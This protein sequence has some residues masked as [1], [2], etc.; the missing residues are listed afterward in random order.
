MKGS[1][2]IVINIHPF[3]GYTHAE[4]VNEINDLIDSIDID[5]FESIKDMIDYINESYKV[6]DR[7]I[8]LDIITD[9]IVN[10]CSKKYTTT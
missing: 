2:P 6:F 3:E 4:I 8:P 9:I 5:D 7:T 10:K 1:I